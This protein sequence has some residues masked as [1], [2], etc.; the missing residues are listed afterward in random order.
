ML[1]QTQIIQIESFDGYAITGKLDLP[2]KDDIQKLVIFV[3]GSGPNTYDNTRKVGDLEFN[4]H[5]IFADELTKRN[6]AYFRY[7][8]RGVNIGSE[9]PLFAQIDELEYSKY[10]PSNSVRDIEA[11]VIG[12]RNNPQLNKTKIYLLGMSEGTI[13]APIVA[14]NS[15]VEIAGL[16]LAGYC[17]D[18]LREIVNWQLSGESSMIFY[19]RL[20]DLDN[21]GFV[22]KHDFEADKFGV[23]SSVLKG[24]SFEQLDINQDGKIDISD[25]QA[26]PHITNWRDAIFKAIDDEDDQWLKQHYSVRLT[27]QWFKE[28]FTLPPN[29]ETLLSLDIPIHIFHGEYDQNCPVNGV[30]DVAERFRGQNKSNLNIH[31]FKDH[32]HDLNYMQYPLKGV[33]SEGLTSIFKVCEEV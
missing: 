31:V 1:R 26:N 8:T 15:T 12:L 2:S 24:V 18:S 3:N 4:Y 30:Y 22:S 33:I 28:H 5:N 13:I 14:K 20:F 27:S 17:N 29:K 19:K 16:L 6:I 10:L 9:P 25:F 21:K 23:R 7:N 11:I 32:D